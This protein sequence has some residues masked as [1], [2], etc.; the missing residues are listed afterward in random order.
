MRFEMPI[1]ETSD[2][3][4]RFGGLEALKDIGL[5]IEEGEIVGIIGPNGAGKST[6][7]NVISGF[8][9]PTTGK[10]VF[11]GNDITGKSAA[12]ICASGLVR[13]FQGTKLFMSLPTVE[14]IQI[15]C[16]VP[17]RTNLVGDIFG[18][19]GTRRRE[20]DARERVSDVVKLAGLESVVRELPKNLPHGYQRSLGVAIGLAA[21]PKLLC[22]D[23]PVTGMNAEEAQL[24]IAM[25]EKLR[26][27]GVTILL[28]E[29][30]MRTVMG[31]CDRVVVL[32]FG[33]QIAAGTPEEIQCNEEVIQA[34]LG[35]SDEVF[36]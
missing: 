15:A 4:K 2:L 34:Y 25:I 36:T 5:R 18:L 29:H 11:D 16:H 1:L 21:N 35:S 26:S 19:P 9:K 22:L 32:N 10:V 20:R 17:A 7:F 23:E 12:S 8:M 33:R 24:M 3:T 30:S 28:V 27:E 14:N 13:T 6:F 31:V